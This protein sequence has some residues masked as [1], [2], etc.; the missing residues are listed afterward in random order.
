MDWIVQYDVP[1]DT[2]EYIHRV[3][4]T[5]RGDSGTGKSILFLMPNELPFLT[6]LK[7]SNIPI[8]KYKYE[9]LV[10]SKI[11]AK[12][13]DIIST[14]YFIGKTAKKGF[15]EFIMRYQ[16]HPLKNDFKI[17]EIDITNAAKA[18]GFTDPPIVNLKF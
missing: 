14:N 15:R 6:L 18:F 4:R 3:G 5:A 2:E 12:I 8:K 10:N 16:Y 9:N 1:E 7:E 17:N 11:Q 13:E